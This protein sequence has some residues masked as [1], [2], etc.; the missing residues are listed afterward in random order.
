ML[1]QPYAAARRT[2]P[3]GLVT[4]PLIEW[5]AIRLTGA[6]L[7]VLA[8]GHLGAMHYGAGVGLRAGPLWL[9]FEWLLLLLALSHAALGLHT[10]VRDAA[11]GAG[12]RL[13]GVAA[14]GAAGLALLAIGSAALLTLSLG[15][16][17][18]SAPGSSDAA[19]AVILVLS[20][21]A[22]AALAVSAALFVARLAQGAPLGRWGLAGQCAWALHRATG[23]ALAGFLAIHVVDVALL[24]V[25]PEVFGRS[26]ASGTRLTLAP[27]ELL[28]VLAVLYH[29]LNGLRLIAMDLWPTRRL[30]GRLAAGTI[31][32]AVALTLPSAVLLLR[33]R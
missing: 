9:G 16:V 10:I 32:F 18:G 6:M 7:F 15:T 28:I 19:R 33:G 12:A 24:P 5:Y 20:L 4:A 23:V 17:A 8:L 26:V 27:I 21:A 1:G 25:A 14:L 30:P 22:Y 29:G 11:A 13:L 2:R 3:R 31:V